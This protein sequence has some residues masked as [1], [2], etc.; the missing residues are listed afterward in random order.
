MV[1]AGG[2]VLMSACGGVG[3]HR[4]EAPTGMLRE[5]GLRAEDDPTVW[6]ARLFPE[7]LEEAHGWGV[8]P[9]GGM[10]AIVAGVRVVSMG[11]GAM[12]VASDRL[13]AT[14]SNVIA[15]PERLGGGFLFAIGTHLWGSKV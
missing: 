14:P 11:S 7:A 1:T 12:V 13:P 9:G 2:L 10:R 3:P 6:G 15:L 8:E 4:G 5:T